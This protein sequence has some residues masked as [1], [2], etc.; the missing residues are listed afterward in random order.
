MNE[1]IFT[2]DLRYFETLEAKSE[3]SLRD[4]IVAY[5]ESYEEYHYI[6]E[7]QKKTLWMK[8]KEFLSTLISSFK[9][10]QATLSIKIDNV[11]EDGKI[12]MRL[13]K[14]VKDLEENKA[15]GST[16][17]IT[18]DVE[19]YKNRYLECY[20]DLWKYARKFERVKYDSVDKIDEDLEA[21]NR[22]YKKYTEELDE[23]GH[24]KIE[25]DIEKVITFCKNEIDKKS[26][27]FK[28]INDTSA[29]LQIMK[30]DAD[31]LETKRNILGADVLPK[32]IGLIRRVT[33]AISRFVKKC[34]TKFITTV[35]F[36]FA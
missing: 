9:T 18:I 3:C 24:E 16:K 14:M 32:H 30:K 25:Q 31:L 34:V 19:K 12:E 8:L 17:V 28:T 27:V 22:L 23:I 35:V 21:F 4:E 36:I 5:F 20:K 33:G 2:E 10:F 15:K 1:M 13:R 11:L 7:A 6:T 29:K 26:E